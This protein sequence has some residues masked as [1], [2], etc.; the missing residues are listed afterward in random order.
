MSPQPP[1][2]IPPRDDVIRLEASPEMVVQVLQ[3]RYPE[4][5]ARCLAEAAAI[6]LSQLAKALQ[7]ENAQL[8]ATRQEGPPDGIAPD[9]PQD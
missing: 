7:A 5:H 2:Q 9:P 8:K 6:E 3:M 1:D 4:Q